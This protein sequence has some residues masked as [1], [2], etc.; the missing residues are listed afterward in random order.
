MSRD[1]DRQRAK[2]Q[3]KATEA[4]T[5]LGAYVVT[6]G[7]GADPA[8]WAPKVI[9]LVGGDADVF[10]MLD[11]KPGLFGGYQ[12]APGNGYGSWLRQVR[13]SPVYGPQL[14]ESFRR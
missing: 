2:L 11:E 7:P 5:R 8:V 9:E 3:V 10:W 1:I 14:F 6:L 13:N 4:A 12:G